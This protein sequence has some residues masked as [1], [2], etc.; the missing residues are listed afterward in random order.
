MFGSV[1]THDIAEVL[2]STCE[3]VVDRRKIHLREPIRTT[4]VHE[5][6]VRLLGEARA[7]MKVEVLD[8]LHASKPAPAPEP[9]AAPVVEAETEE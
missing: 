6:D 2:K 8:S 1:T 4:G 3:V 5:I 7:T 9:V